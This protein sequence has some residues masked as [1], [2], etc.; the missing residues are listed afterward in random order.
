MS[1]VQ[2]FVLT[3][4]VLAAI[5]VGWFHTNAEYAQTQS[6]AALASLE[7]AL[8]PEYDRPE[9]LVIYR[10]LVA[11]S[12]PLPAA[13]TFTLPTTVRAVN[14]VAYLDPTSN[15]LLNISDYTLNDNAAGRVISFSTPARRF[16]FE[17][18]AAGLLSRQGDIRTLAFT[19]AAPTAVDDARFEVQ[20]P[21]GAQSGS[22]NPSPSVTEVRDDGLTYAV[23]R[24]GSLTPGESRSLQAT[25]SRSSDTLSTDT[26]GSGSTTPIPSAPLQPNGSSRD[27][28]LTLILIAL[29]ILLLGGGIVQYLWFR[30]RRPLARRGTA[31]SGSREKHQTAHCHRCG[32]PL[33]EDAE[34]CHACGTRRRKA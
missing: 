16:Q 1:R 26:L 4:A 32:T 20:Q 34:F 17:Y 14:A 22:S 11:E 10:G 23:Y 28:S 18:Y 12:A 8:W 21:V 5:T 6:L 2:R 25:Y 24:L 31:P 9:V 15:K 13:V 27:N 7:I 30:N 33:R 19:F 29:G 3:C